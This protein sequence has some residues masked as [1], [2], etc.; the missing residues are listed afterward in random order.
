MEIIPS[1]ATASS[2]ELAAV[3]RANVTSILDRLRQ[4]SG[5]HSIEG[6]TGRL[7]TFGS[8][9]IVRCASGAME[10]RQLSP[11]S[12][13]SVGSALQQ[14]QM[15][16]IAT[17]G[18]LISGEPVMLVFATSAWRLLILSTSNSLPQV[19]VG[20]HFVS[21]QPANW[22]FLNAKLCAQPRLNED[23]SSHVLSAWH[24]VVPEADVEGTSLFLSTVLQHALLHS[25][26]DSKESK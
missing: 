14:A 1:A 16:V 21:A 24:A 25:T 11:W 23:T 15:D 8:L 26:T 4:Q 20:G 13:C 6:L 19:S 7:L 22:R 5:K 12:M 18:T 2:G 3:V 17:P 10:T 9:R